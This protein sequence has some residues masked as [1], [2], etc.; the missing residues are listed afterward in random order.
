MNLVNTCT[1][2]LSIKGI[3]IKKWQILSQILGAQSLR[4]RHKRK[5][6]GLAHIPIPTTLHQPAI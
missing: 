1:I 3:L 5:Y 4:M 2:T 6:Q